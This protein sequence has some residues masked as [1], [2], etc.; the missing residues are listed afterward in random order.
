MVGI[1]GKK[2]SGFIAAMGNFS[3]QYNLSSASVVLPPSIM[4][5]IYD[6]PSWSTYTLKGLVFAGA[7]VGMCVMGYLGD[8]IGRKRAMIFTLSLTV[9]GALGCAL[10]PW[11]DDANVIYAV[12]SA[13]RFIL[14]VGVGGIY[15]LS[16][17]TASEGAVN[18]ESVVRDVGMAFFWQTPGAMAPY[19]VGLILL[20]SFHDTKE[21]T[22]MEFRLIMG[23]GAVFAGIVLVSAF[24]FEDSEE[25]TS[26]KSRSPFHE[27][28]E[29]RHY[30]RILVGTA[31]TWFLYDVAFYGTNIFTPDIIESIFGKDDNVQL[32]WH[33]LVAQAIGIPGCLL[34]IYLLRPKGVYWLMLWGFVLIGVF[35]AAFAIVYQI[36]PDGYPA[37]KYALYCLLT[38]SL[39]F[40]PNVATFI[41]PAVSFPA[42]VRGIF[43][44]L[45]A[46]CAKLGAVVGTYAFDP[47]EDAWGM[48]GLLWMQ[49]GLCAVGVIVTYFFVERDAERELREESENAPL[50]DPIN[51]TI[52]Y[53]LVSEN[54]DA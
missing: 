3:I 20:V 11:G 43:H 1:G 17:A 54:R 14:G 33:S 32:C 27:A 44:G 15:P 29:H 12:L 36:S 52:K 38:F 21:V 51:Q 6:E 39:N 2:K 45:S 46:A 47:M 19:L 16:A 23:L 24:G 42:N 34:A 10:F 9:L 7:M 53:G 35:F 48:P 50:V 22:E 37:L 28:L 18:H 31:G 41:L 40:G 5:D 49:T 13:C 30:W 4:S 8:L 25:F 26:H